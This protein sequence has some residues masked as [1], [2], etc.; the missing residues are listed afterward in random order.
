MFI[1]YRPEDFDIIIYTDKEDKPPPY[2]HF[3]PSTS[4]NISSINLGSIYLNQKPPGSQEITE[5]IPKELQFLI[6]EEKEVYEKKH[7]THDKKLQWP[8]T[9]TRDAHK[10]DDVFIARANN[11]FGHSV[12]WK[13][14]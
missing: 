10:D 14:R 6:E 12:K 3:I 11:P 9:S 5:D 1:S 13:Y 8:I 2:H 4:T 7:G